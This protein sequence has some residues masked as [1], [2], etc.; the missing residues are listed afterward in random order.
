MK[1]EGF[2]YLDVE[3][4]LVAW[5]V[6]RG[7]LL[8]SGLVQQ[9]GCGSACVALS[10]MAAN[11]FMN[12]DRERYQFELELEEVRRTKFPDRMS[13]LSC[14]YVFDT[15]ESALAAASDEAWSGGHILH[16]NLTDIGVSAAPNHT[17]CDANWISW[18]REHW[19]ADEGEWREGIEPYWEGKP[20]PHYAEPIWEVLLEGAVTIWSKS[21]RERAYQVT[22]EY[23]PR[24]VCLLE[25]ARLAATLGS[26]LGHCSALITFEQGRHLMSFYIDMRDAHNPIFTDKLAAY[27]KQNPAIVNELDLSV[28]GGKFYTPNFVAYSYVFDAP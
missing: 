11:I 5:N 1:F 7:A 13:R 16:E 3:N 22:K 24:A 23:S 26:D 2:M 14:L 19:N 9:Q 12:Q 4:P 25:Q 17:R 10:M 18:M 8:S 15:P 27:I 28:G 20:C 21:L 6:Y